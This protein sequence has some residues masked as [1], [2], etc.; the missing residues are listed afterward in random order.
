[1]SGVASEAETEPLREGD[2]RSAE[3]FTS[4][5]SA[6]SLRGAAAPKTKRS[7]GARALSTML[8]TCFVAGYFCTL[9]TAMQRYHP[10]AFELL[11]KWLRPSGLNSH[12]L[13]QFVVIVGLSSLGAMGLV[14]VTQFLCVKECTCRDEKLLS[15]LPPTASRR[16]RLGIKWSRMGGWLWYG[17]VWATVVTLPFALL[18]V[19]SRN[20]APDDVAFF[21]ACI[22]TLLATVFSIREVVKHLQNF[23]KPTAELQVHVIRILWMVPIYAICSCLSLRLP[24]SQSKYLTIVRELYEAFTIWSFM[25]RPASR[26]VLARTLTAP[27]Q[28]RVTLSLR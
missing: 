5:G 24:E 9:L 4:L 26:S 13:D 11:P 14:L 20:W 17:T 12:H 16:W 28:S 1:M 21:L 18:E 23:H 25:A 7:C 6:A 10:Q 22:F 19:I 27:G 8:V 2:A 3:S 15:A